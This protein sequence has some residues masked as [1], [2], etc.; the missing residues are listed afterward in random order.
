MLRNTF[1]HIP[2]VGIKTEQHLWSK[3]I[4]SWEDLLKVD[5]DK[6]KQ[7]KHRVLGYKAYLSYSLAR[8]EN[9]DAAYFG[10]LLPSDQVWR[11]F[12]DFR[13][14]TAYLDIE[15]TGMGAFEDHITTI[16]L[17]DGKRVRWYVHGENLDEFARDI[18]QYKIVVTYNGKGFDIPFIRSSLRVPMDQVQID[19]RYVLKSL[20]YRGGLKGCEKQ[21]GIVRNELDGV[22]GFFAVLL[23]KEYKNTNN[24]KALETLLAYNILDAVNLEALMVIVYNRKLRATPFEKSDTIPEPSLPRFPFQPDIGTIER[25]KAKLSGYGIPAGKWHSESRTCTTAYHS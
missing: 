7:N 22:D 20:G 2:G 13:E 24:R 1:C 14:D 5:A 15:T 10:E 11:L 19:L 17:Y 25:I 3:G 6:L 12:P 18:Q 16:A 9:G 8:F 4:L 23:W 21:L